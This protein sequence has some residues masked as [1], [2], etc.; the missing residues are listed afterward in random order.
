MKIKALSVLY[1]WP[2]KS[3]E[4]KRL[5]IWPFFTFKENCGARIN[6][7]TKYSKKEHF[8]MQ[9]HEY[10]DIGHKNSSNNKVVKRV[11]SNKLV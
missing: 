7:E 5:E 8:L 4:S 3:Q 6:S 1:N 10:E 11:L 9:K 2:V